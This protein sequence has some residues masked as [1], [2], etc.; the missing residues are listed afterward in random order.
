MKYKSRR[1]NSSR[2]SSHWLT[3]DVA[4]VSATVVAKVATETNTAVWT[5]EMMPA[6]VTVTSYVMT[7]VT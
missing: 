5:R 2:H 6:V 1:R 7:D 3:D 4:T